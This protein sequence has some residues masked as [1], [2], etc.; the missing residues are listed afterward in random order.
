MTTSSAQ[1]PLRGVW[2]AILTPLEADGRI[3]YDLLAA[4]CRS[5][6]AKGVDGV[7]LF[8][9]TG[10]GQSFSVAERKEA[11]EQL[12]A[13]GIPAARV[14]VG[15]GCS[16]LAE[17]AELSRHAA[18]FGVAGVLVLP[19]FFF[20]GL[21]DE[22]VYDAFAR[23]CEMLKGV[24]TR[25]ILYHIPQVS[26]VAVSPAVVA[27]LA[28]SFPGLIGGVKDSSGDWENTAL[29]LKLAPDLAIMVGHEPYLPRLLKAG[30]VGTICGIANY[31]PDLIRRLFD[32]AGKPEEAGLVSVVEK[33]CNLVTDVPFVPALKALMVE[34]TGEKRW[35]NVRAPLTIPDAAE[36]R[37]LISAAKTLE[38]EVQAAA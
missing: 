34:Q 23:L 15:T 22:G 32:A 5:L 30:G 3:A 26:A 4:H 10:E 21:S 13:A 9:T 28:K 35:L 19:P 31:R 11:L 14:T 2:T 37:R 36:Q 6:F 12:L 25:M 33:V 7:T 20:K 8:G 17:T 1:A 27:R 18:A 38:A 16:A 24:R 29:L